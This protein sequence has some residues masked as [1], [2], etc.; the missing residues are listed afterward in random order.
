M[1]DDIAVKAYLHKQSR[2]WVRLFSTLSPTRSLQQNALLQLGLRHIA[3]DTCECLDRQGSRSVA[4]QAPIISVPDLITAPG[5]CESQ[6]NYGILKAQL[7]AEHLAPS[8]LTQSDVRPNP[9]LP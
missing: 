1:W 3:G 4:L 7:T 6:S 9:I 8:R 5:P 2:A